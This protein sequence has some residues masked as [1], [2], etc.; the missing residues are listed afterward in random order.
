MVRAGL[1]TMLARIERRKG[2]SSVKTQCWS[3]GKTG[4]SDHNRQ[5]LHNQPPGPPGSLIEYCLWDY[6][7]PERAYRRTGKAPVERAEESSY[8]VAT[9]VIVEVGGLHSPGSPA[10]LECWCPWT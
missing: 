1:W 7:H 6:T 3:K 9:F 2:R 10:K 4:S 5:G 8:D